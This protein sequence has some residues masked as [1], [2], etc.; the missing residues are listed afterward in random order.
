MDTGAIQNKLLPLCS[1]QEGNSI[2]ESNV[3][4][5]AHTHSLRE[6]LQDFV[7]ETFEN[8]QKL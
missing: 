8:K 3:I 6:A 5:T 1:K 4:F 2:H 7:V